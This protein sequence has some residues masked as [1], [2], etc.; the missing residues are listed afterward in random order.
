MDP[1]LCD[2]DW[3]LSWLACQI[4]RLPSSFLDLWH[5]SGALTNDSL[6]LDSGFLKVFVAVNEQ[7]SLRESRGIDEIIEKLVQERVLIPNG[8]DIGIILRQRYLVF[9]ILGWQSMLFLPSFTASSLDQFA[10]Y[11][12]INQPN[13]RLVFDTFTMSTDLAD[14]EMA[15]LL[16]GFGNLLPARAPDLPKVASETSKVVSTSFSIDPAA[17]NMHVLSTL[18]RVRVRWVDTLALHLDY[19]QTT[20]TLSLFRF[21]SFCVATLRSTGALYSF[22]SSERRSPDPRANHDEITDILN[23]TLS[24]Y[25]LLFGRSKSSRQLFRRLFKEHSELSINGDKL[26]YSLCTEQHFEHAIVPKDRAMYSADR[27]FP[28]LGW[29]IKALVEEL[30]EAKPKRWKDMV[31]DRRDAVQYWTFWLVAIFGAAS[32]VLSSIQVLL[33]GLSLK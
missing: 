3:Y 24:S 21:P 8:D 18:L 31:R 30:K 26:L 20:R 6:S 16:K 5:D 23:E 10:I 7:V 19:D 2:L 4:A 22:A 1:N 15:T 32:I 11:Q 12:D 9:S 25:R 17:V 33:Q 29:R 27:D 28:V 13:S 14:R